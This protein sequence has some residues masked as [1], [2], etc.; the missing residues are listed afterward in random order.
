MLVNITKEASS[1]INPIEKLMS[2]IKRDVYPNGKQYS[3]KMY[4]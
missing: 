4:Q 3:N 1:D 2:I